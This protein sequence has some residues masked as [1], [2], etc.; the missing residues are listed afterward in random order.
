MFSVIFMEILMNDLIDS[1]ISYV[2]CRAGATD[3]MATKSISRRC[4]H[5]SNCPKLF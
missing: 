3:R 2:D 4:A 5:I 1:Y